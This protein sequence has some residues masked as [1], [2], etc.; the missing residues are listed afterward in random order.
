MAR[1]L[2]LEKSEVW[3]SVNKIKTGFELVLAVIFSSQLSYDEREFI[4][5]HLQ[6][7]QKVCQF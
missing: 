3:R 6:C 5:P 4:N 2:C 7:F 1:I